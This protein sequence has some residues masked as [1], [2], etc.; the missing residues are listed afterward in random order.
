MCYSFPNYNSSV[1]FSYAEF[2]YV[3]SS[4]LKSPRSLM[5]VKINFVEYVHLNGYFKTP[6]G[7][8]KKQCF[9]CAML[10]YDFQNKIK[11]YFSN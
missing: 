9:I 1:Q 5:T 7:S 4:F 10:Y 11:F 3:F 6:S 8:S 2:A